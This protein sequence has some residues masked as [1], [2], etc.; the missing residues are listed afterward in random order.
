MQKLILENIP[1][2]LEELGEGYS[3]I[4]NEYPIK[5]GNT[6]NYIDMLLFN[7][8]YNCY[9]VVELKITELKKEHIGQIQVYMNYINENIKTINQNKT[10]GVII[11][12]I[13][14]KNIIKYS[15][16]ERIISRTYELI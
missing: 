3:F 1:S 2:F 15:S 12:R 7:I 10:V 14:N 6:Y 4:K 13:N 5:I 11:T 8:K 16:D 9:I